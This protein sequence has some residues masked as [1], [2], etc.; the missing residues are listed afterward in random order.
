[1]DSDFDKWSSVKK[2][3]NRDKNFRSFKERDIFYTHFGKNIGFEQNGRGDSFI[4]PVI[5]L[6]KFNKSIF[7]AIPL[8]TQIKEGI[9]YFKF[10]FLK[11][12]RDRVENIALLS[13]VK[14]LDSKR[15]LNKIGT[16]DKDSFED[17]KVRYKNQF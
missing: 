2:I 17:L 15:L 7:V 4:R 12:R 11:N 13:Q 6:K 8:S 1:L 16:I 14:T 9:Y 3:V 10:S 5:V